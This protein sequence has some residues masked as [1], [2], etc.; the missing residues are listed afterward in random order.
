MISGAEFP[1]E[2]RMQMSK[3]KMKNTRGKET[4]L[5]NLELDE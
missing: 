2:A 4:P 1:Q 3:Q 5:S